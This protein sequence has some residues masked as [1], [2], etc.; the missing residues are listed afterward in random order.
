MD[1]C[2]I[3]AGVNKITIGAE[4]TAISGKK[5]KLDSDDAFTLTVS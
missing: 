3:L 5:R 1:D 4:I 2:F